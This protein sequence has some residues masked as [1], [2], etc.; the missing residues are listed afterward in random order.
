[1]SPIIDQLANEVATR[2]GT[3]ALGSAAALLGLTQMGSASAR[4]NGKKKKSCKKE[5]QQK[6]EDAC[7]PQAGECAAFFSS[8]CSQFDDPQKCVSII[9]SCCAAL[10]ECRFTEAIQCLTTTPLE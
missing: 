8:S 7:G 1:M 5:A 2:R 4:K 6:V 3:L 10:G 9:T